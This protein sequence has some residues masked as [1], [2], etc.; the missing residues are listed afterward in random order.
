MAFWQRK[1]NRRVFV[2]YREGGKTCTVP[3]DEVR[4]LDPEPDHNVQA[5]VEQFDLR[6]GIAKPVDALDEVWARRVES[7]LDSRRRSAKTDMDHRHALVTHV[8]PY[9]LNHCG[10]EDPN[11]WPTRSGQFRTWARETAGLTEHQLQKANTAL[12]AFWEWLGDEQL[13]AAHMA[14]RIR[15]ANREATQ[16]PLRFTYTPEE[17]LAWAAPRPDDCPFALMGLAG[18]AFSLRPYEHPAMRRARF[19]AGEAATRLDCGRLM[20]SYGLYARLAFHVETQIGSDGVEKKPKANY[21]TWLACPWESLARELVRRLKAWG[22]EAE[23]RLLAAY[24]TDTWLKKWKLVAPRRRLE[25]GTEVWLTLKDL[26]R[27]SLKHLGH[28]TK[29][30]ENPTAFL[31]HSRHT[32]FETAMLYCRAPGERVAAADDLDLDA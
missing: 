27:A 20:A 18:Y 1:S 5:W 7:F 23:D 2:Y 19:V 13:R 30:G 4:H 12:R 3:R 14:L 22:G 16:T 28:H 6:R 9:F 32:K 26:R 11:H 29:L 8:I 24:S 21:V 17:I 31:R 25:D 10:L 15:Q